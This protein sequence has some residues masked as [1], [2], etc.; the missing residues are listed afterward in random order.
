MRWRTDSYKLRFRIPSWGV[1]KY[2][3]TEKVR[4]FY[5]DV[6]KAYLYVDYRHPIAYAYAGLRK[7]ADRPLSLQ[8]KD[9]E[10]GYMLGRMSKER[11]LGFMKVRVWYWVK[12]P[13]RLETIPPLYAIHHTQHHT[14]AEKTVEKIIGKQN[15]EKIKNNLTLQI[16][17]G[18]IVGTTVYFITNKL[19]GGKNGK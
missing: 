12:F 7:P 2:D 11:R 16:L 17:S 6:K 4:K 14:H 10:H 15:I 8:I 1:K 13:A 18:V 19:L 3:V 5:P 9:W